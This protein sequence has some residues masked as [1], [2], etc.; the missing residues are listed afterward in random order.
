MHEGTEENY[1]QPVKVACVPSEARKGHFMYANL[2]I[3]SMIICLVYSGYR[4]IIGSNNKDSNWTHPLY[5]TGP[6]H[7][8]MLGLCRGDNMQNTKT[9][10]KMN[11]NLCLT[12]S[13]DKHLY[14]ITIIPVVHSAGV[15]VHRTSNNILTFAGL[16]AKVNLPCATC[17]ESFCGSVVTAPH[18]ANYCDD[19]DRLNV[20]AA[21]RYP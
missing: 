1:E 6:R 4:M 16:T 20:S 13:T 14:V 2:I 17:H 7:G 21:T 15:S 3:T 18:I 8:T 12:T 5:T 19:E 9:L 10:M 11:K